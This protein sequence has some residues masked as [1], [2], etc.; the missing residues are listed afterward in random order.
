M[1]AGVFLVAHDR[2]LTGVVM[3]AGG[4]RLMAPLV[5]TRPVAG[6]PGPVAL[7]TVGGALAFIVPGPLVVPVYR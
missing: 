3:A 1:V 4:H 6:L 2:L 7:L 5:G